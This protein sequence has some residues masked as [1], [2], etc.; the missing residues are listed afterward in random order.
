[1][2]NITGR[3]RVYLGASWPAS[4]KPVSDLLALPI[5]DG[6]SEWRW[7]RLSNGDLMLGFFP[8]ANGQDGYFLTEIDREEDWCTADTH[9]TMSEY[10]EDIENV[11]LPR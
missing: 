2:E 7:L 9:D 5:G 4:A 10:M 8:Q 11:V 6:R 1:M 3:D